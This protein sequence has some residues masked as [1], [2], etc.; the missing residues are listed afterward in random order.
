MVQSICFLSIRIS[1]NKIR[2]HSKP[3][4][5]SLWSPVCDESF[6]SLIAFIEY[7]IFP[8]LISHPLIFYTFYLTFNI[9]QTK[10]AG[11]DKQ[12]KVELP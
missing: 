9:K 1:N 2:L 7:Y 10:V 11:S 4:G 12:L 5:Y 3:L 8:L 6:N